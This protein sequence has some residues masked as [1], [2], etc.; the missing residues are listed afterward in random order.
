MDLNTVSNIT[1]NIPNRNVLPLFLC[2]HVK[3]QCVMETQPLD[4][5]HEV[6]EKKFH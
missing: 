6:V 5:F 1:E 3:I 2:S 4:P